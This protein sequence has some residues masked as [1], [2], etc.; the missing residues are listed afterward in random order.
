MSI[1]EPILYIP[2]P[3]APRKKKPA[4]QSMQQHVNYSD[5]IQPLE[6]SISDKRSMHK[7]SIDGSYEVPEISSIV[8]FS[9]L[10]LTICIAN[11]GNLD[12]YRPN[13]RQQH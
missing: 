2:V 7:P 1:F 4:P 5:I 13:L 8:P 10:V 6:R 11:G 3:T 12:S 9:T